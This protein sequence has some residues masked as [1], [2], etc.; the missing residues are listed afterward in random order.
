[1][2]KFGDLVLRNRYSYTFDGIPLVARNLSFKK[3]W[4]LLLAGIDM[5][6]GSKRVLAR[7]PV[8]HIEPTNICNLKC[9][10]C[11]TGAGT[12]SRPKGVMVYETYQQIIGE[13][14]ETLVAVYFFCFGEPFINKQLPQMIKD[15]TA[16][17]IL[18]LTST[19]GHFLQ[20]PDEA[21]EVVDAGLKVL[22][23]ALDGSNQEVYQAYRKN[24]DFDKVKRCIA[25][26]EEAKAKSGS[27]FPYTAL[28]TVVSKENE[29]DLTNIEKLAKQ[30][31]VNMFTYKSLGCL[32]D[33]QQ[34]GD[35][36]PEGN[37]MRRFNLKKGGSEKEA[38]VR[39]PFPF[40]QPIFFW[41]GSLVGCEYDHNK[42][43]VFGKVGNGSILDYMN[44]RNAQMLRSCVLGETESTNFCR[45]RCPYKNRRQDSSNLYCKEFCPI[46]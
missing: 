7:P 3:K 19:N 13:L 42:E 39:C 20:T 28:R 41:D 36:E 14:A 23:V 30:L 10:L 2:K 8:I 25:Q 17:N 18:T 31:G 27:N 29:G 45:D 26:I 21:M 12:L 1:M 22:I 34:F 46:R 40:R 11:P 43:Y 15:C 32:V 4:N 38:Q 44:S 5:V 35:F 16:R 6:T 37:Q 24:G 9:P 33:G